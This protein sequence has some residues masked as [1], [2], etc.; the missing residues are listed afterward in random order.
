MGTGSSSRGDQHPFFR[1]PLTVVL[2]IYLLL[3]VFFAGLGYWL[4][5]DP[6]S[7]AAGP[8]GVFVGMMLLRLPPLRR[9]INEH[10]ARRNGMKSPDV[11]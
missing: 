7:G 4:S 10:Y 5:G 11:P 6:W 8:I 3:I 2:P 1:A 9:R